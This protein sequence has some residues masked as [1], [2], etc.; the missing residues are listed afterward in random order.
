[1]KVILLCML[2]AVAISAVPH[3]PFALTPASAEQ[4]GGISQEAFAQ[5]HLLSPE[6]PATP[7]NTPYNSPT[8]SPMVSP[9]TSPMASPERILND[10]EQPV[11]A[12]EGDPI[13]LA[14]IIV[15]LFLYFSN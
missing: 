5:F 14:A 1:M 2:F 6:V 3:N 15:A 4:Q 9:P 8:V 12:L 7:T 13:M 10:D 11:D